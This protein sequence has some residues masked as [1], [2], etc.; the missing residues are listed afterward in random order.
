MRP[1]SE[2]LCTCVGLAI[3]FVVLLGFSLPARVSAQ[4]VGAT[5]SGTIVDATGSV[6]PGVKI[7]F[8]NASTGSIANGA[9]NG[10]GVFNVPNLP[11]GDYE[12]AASA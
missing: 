4:M 2:F 5:V 11:P 1:R 7:V 9:T 6:V 12:L 10:V 3:T 8:K